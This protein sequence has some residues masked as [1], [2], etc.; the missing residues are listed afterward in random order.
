[1]LTQWTDGHNHLY[2]Y[3]YDEVDPAHATAKL[4][5]QLTKGDFEV[6][7]VLHVEAANRLVD[8]TSNEGNP[9][10][11]QLWQVN[12]KGERKQLSTGSG[13]HPGNFSP[14][15]NAFADSQSSRMEPPTLKLCAAAGKC[16]IF[17]STRALEPY[18]LRTP[19]QLEVKA[20][21]GT[22]LYATLLLPE[23]APLARRACR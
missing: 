5:R 1:M 9:L 10:D 6:S 22:A 8:Y 23:G 20:H 7:E 17:W 12:F 13:V 15:G 19:A 4:E 3:S 2:L 16:S 21:D 18:K 14:A 11:Q